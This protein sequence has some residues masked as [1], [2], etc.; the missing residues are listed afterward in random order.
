VRQIL[1][2]FAVIIAIL[3]M[4]SLD[5]YTGVS[6]PKLQVNMYKSRLSIWR[7][8]LGVHEVFTVKLQG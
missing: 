8:L 1:S 2:D 3:V 6:T 7:E 4:S 5:Y